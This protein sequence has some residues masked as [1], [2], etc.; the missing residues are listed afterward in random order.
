MP[1]HK[2]IRTFGKVITLTKLSVYIT[3]TK[4]MTAT[5]YRI[6]SFKKGHQLQVVRI[7]KIVI[8]IKYVFE[9][10]NVMMKKILE[11]IKFGSKG[12]PLHGH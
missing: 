7:Y 10:K 9:K 4:I 3:T 1:L 6:I 5:D 12:F 8:D 11:M 2:M